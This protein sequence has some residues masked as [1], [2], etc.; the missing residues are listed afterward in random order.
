MCTEEMEK[1]FMPNAGT[2]QSSNVFQ[3]KSL[4]EGV[5]D[6]RDGHKTVLKL[7]KIDE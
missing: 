5:K 7:S 6:F 4:R 2:K 3:V 1:Q